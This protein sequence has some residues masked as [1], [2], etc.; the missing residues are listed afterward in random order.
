VPKVRVEGPEKLMSLAAAAWI[1]VR[2]AVDRERNRMNL[3]GS[4]SR[5]EPADGFLH[6]LVRRQG[7][8]VVNIFH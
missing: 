7:D 3:K 2:M 8:E 5:Q 6:L 1:L 4:R